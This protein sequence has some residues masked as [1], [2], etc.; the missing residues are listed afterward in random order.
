MLTPVQAS[1]NPCLIIPRH[2][3]IIT[4]RDWLI[5]MSIVNVDSHLISP[6]PSF[7]RVFVQDGLIVVR[8]IL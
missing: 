5:V 3:L 1:L 2:L 4:C 7:A 6:G 8:S